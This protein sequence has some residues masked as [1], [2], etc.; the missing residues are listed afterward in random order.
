MYIAG[1]LI[2][3]ELCFLL[4]EFIVIVTNPYFESTFWLVYLLFLGPL[5]AAA[6]IYIIYFWN[7]DS[8]NA[9]SCLP[10]A[11]ILAILTNIL[12]IIWIILYIYKFD[13]ENKVTVHKSVRSST[14]KC[15]D[16]PEDRE[17]DDDKNRDRGYGEQDKTTYV[18]LHCLVPVISAGILFYY[19][20]VISDWVR[21]HRH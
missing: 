4:I 19:Y 17:F 16:R 1:I 18:L 12:I 7:Q 5:I 8:P 6:I 20:L 15:N 21:R 14:E 11:L 3:A 10:T 9:R 13:H 2:I